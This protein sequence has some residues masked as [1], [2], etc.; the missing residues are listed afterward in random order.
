MSG[1]K[2]T[3]L[4]VEAGLGPAIEGL[5]RATAEAYSPTRKLSTAYF[6]RSPCRSADHWSVMPLW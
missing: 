1:L 6:S 3:L 2:H 5:G 4:G